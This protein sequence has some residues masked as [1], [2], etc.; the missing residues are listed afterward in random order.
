MTPQE[1][2]LISQLFQRLKQA[3]PQEKD[4]EAEGLIS[5]G[6]RDQP[7]APYLLVQT[8]LIQDMTLTNAQAR[9]AEMERE[10]A[11]AKSA[12]APRRVN[13][14]LGGLLHGSVPSTGAAPRGPD[15]AP[16]PQ[17][18]ASSAP[19]PIPMQPMMSGGGS[20]FLRAAAATALGVVGGE[21][22]FQGVHSMFGGHFGMGG[23]GM[24]IQPSLSETVINNYYDE[25]GH[26]GA[27]GAHHAESAD[28]HPDAAGQQSADQSDHDDRGQDFADQ[29]LTNQDVAG[30]FESGDGFGGDD[31]GLA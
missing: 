19:G 5:Q 7:D 28:H 2:Q 4:P 15:P 17:P 25:P 20:G 12:Q 21:L 8:V 13:S 23:F 26:H 1:Q 31:S 22:L 18:Q 9:I 29:D 14:F 11:A 3:P 27:G 16:E 6:L 24:P 30:D 10:L